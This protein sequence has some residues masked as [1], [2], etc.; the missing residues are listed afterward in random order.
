MNA[1]VLAKNSESEMVF[2]ALKDG[3]DY[4]MK[5][6]IFTSKEAKRSTI[7]EAIEPFTNI[8][9]P[10]IKAQEAIAKALDGKIEVSDRTKVNTSMRIFCAKY[11]NE[12]YASRHLT[13]LVGHLTRYDVMDFMKKDCTVSLDDTTY[14]ECVLNIQGGMALVWTGNAGDLNTAS[15]RGGTRTPLSLILEPDRVIQPLS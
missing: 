9:S 14:A 6:L 7:R 13:Q 11:V 3:D 5:S 8:T 10:C 1:T 15:T 12:E 4:G 2:D